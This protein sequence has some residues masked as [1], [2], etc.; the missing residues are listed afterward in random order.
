MAVAVNTIS[1]FVLFSFSLRY[2]FRN[3]IFSVVSR[4]HPM[5]L[6]CAI[7]SCPSDSIL[8]PRARRFLV[9]GHWSVTIKP[10]GS[11]DENGPILIL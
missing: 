1:Y 10:S 3:N 9:T 11:G 7:F 6:C 4:V 5:I 2:V 8:V